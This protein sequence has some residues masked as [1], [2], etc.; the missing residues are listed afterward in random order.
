MG[1]AGCFN[2]ALENGGT[3]TNARGH[4]TQGGTPRPAYPLGTEKSALES[5]QGG[6]TGGGGTVHAESP[7]TSD[8][9]RVTET[10]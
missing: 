6:F 7:L 2:T 8:S 9:S 3:S 10:S 1:E 5:V 4:Q